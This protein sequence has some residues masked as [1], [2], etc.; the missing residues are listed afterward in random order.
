MAEKANAPNWKKI[1]AEYLRGGISQQKLADKYGV[2]IRTLA[3]H[4]RLEKWTELR[5]GTCIKVAGKLQEKIA[6]S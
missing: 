1:K 6:D 3:E 4:A 2:P 5:N